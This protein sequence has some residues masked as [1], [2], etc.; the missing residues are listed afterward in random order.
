VQELWREREQLRRQYASLVLLDIYNAGPNREREHSTVD[1]SALSSRIKTIE[2]QLRQNDAAYS[3]LARLDQVSLD[4]VGLALRP[5]EALVEYVNY[6]PYDFVGRT[7]ESGRYGA[8][9]LLGGSGRVVA[10]DLGGAKAIDESVG[11]FRSEMR[12]S[13]DEFKSIDEVNSA[14]VRRSERQIAVA[15]SALRERIWKPLEQYLTGV[16]RIYMAPDG[17]LSLIPFEAMAREDQF[18]AWRYLAEEREFVYVGTGRDLGR[19]SLSALA[20]SHPTKTAVLIGNPNFNESPRELAAVVAGLKTVNKEVVARSVYRSGSGSSTMGATVT[21]GTKRLDVPRNWRGGAGL[22]ELIDEARLQLRRLGWS[23]IALTKDEATEEAVEGLQAPRIVQFATH[24]YVLDRPDTAAEG[25]D[26]PLLRSMLLLAGANKSQP[27]DS[28]Y[29][30]VGREVLSEPESRARGLS[31]KQLQED[32]MILGDGI[33][34]AYE[35][36]GMNLQGTE[37]VNLTAC[38]TGLG[39]VTPEGVAGLR[40]AFLLA[41]ARSLT[42][43]MWEVPAKETTQQVRDF[44]D[45]WLGA[46]GMKPTVRYKAFRA[47]QLAALARARQTHG[48]GHP[49]YWAGV[50]FVGDPGDLPAVRTEPLVAAKK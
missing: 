4:D 17:M 49:F 5:G 30:R 3:K 39:E 48:A 14:K 45:R 22:D 10:L 9:L 38:E 8:L 47:S 43:S 26:N 16:N 35:V 13:I 20:G 25:W 2:Q 33:L 32:R 42:M 18:G 7:S 41:G 29:Y 6:R 34:T 12:A 50:V 28:V 1:V 31:E 11:H 24:G 36:T 19:L 37:M 23:V 44:Y 40:Q 21:G 27:E 46:K 15:S